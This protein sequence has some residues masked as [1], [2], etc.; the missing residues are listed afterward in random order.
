MSAKNKKTNTYLSKS[1]F[2]KGLQCH[3]Y[4]YL[5][6]YHSDLKDEISDQ[7][8]A[9]FQSGTEIGLYAQKLFPNGVEIPYDGLSHSEQLKKTSDEIK[10]GTTTIYEATFSYDNIFVKVDILHKGKEGWEIYEVKASTEVK[11]VHKDDIAVQ[12]YVLKGCGLPVS[13]VFLVYINNQYVRHGDIEVSKLFTVKDLTETVIEKQDYVKENI[14]KMR[15]MLLMSDIPD[16]D[17]GEH[18]SAPY[19]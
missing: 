1:L 4:L 5:E 11:D 18:C 10:K 14:K 8:E 3:K 7:Q 9:L 2:I 17:I 12:Y 13:K 6:K 19:N 16:L 15:E